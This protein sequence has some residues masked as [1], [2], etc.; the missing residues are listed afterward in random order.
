VLSF[1]VFEV[2]LEK[3]ESDKKEQ[4]WDHGWQIELGDI[5]PFKEFF[6]QNETKLK[7]A[8]DST[9]SQLQQ[10]L[11]MLLHNYNVY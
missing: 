4:R 1:L 8:L 7:P 10:L 3:I 5:R 11:K 6:E 2:L 9:K